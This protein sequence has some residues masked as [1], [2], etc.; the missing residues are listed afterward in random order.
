MGIQAFFDVADIKSAGVIYLPGEETHWEENEE[1]TSYE[2][3]YV[4]R[5]ATLIF[6]NGVTHS[7]HRTEDDTL[8]IDFNRWGGNRPVLEPLFQ[9]YGIPYREG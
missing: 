9:Q 1:A 3:A 5:W 8:W 2:V 7:V 4:D 6:P